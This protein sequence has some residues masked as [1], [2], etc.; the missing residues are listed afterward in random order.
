MH[1]HTVQI[2]AENKR[3]NYGL[4][5]PLLNTSVKLEICTKLGAGK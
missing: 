4:P 5:H 3:E 2:G 1:M